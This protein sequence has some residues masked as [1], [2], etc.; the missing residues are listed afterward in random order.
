VELLDFET[1][2]NHDLISSEVKNIDLPKSNVLQFVTEKGSRI[3]VRPSG[4]EPKIKFYVSV[5]STL[6]END[7]Y[8]EKKTA[9]TSQMTALFHAVG[10]A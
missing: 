8:L 3:T 9:L 5:N 7:D 4:T 1:Q 10:A 6:Q 2:K